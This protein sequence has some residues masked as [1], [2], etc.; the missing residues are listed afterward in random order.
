MA[1]NRNPLSYTG[2]V[3]ADTAR[4]GDAQFDSGDFSVDDNGKV[5]LAAAS[6]AETFSTDSGTVTPAS[7]A[8]TVSGGEGIDT[9]GSGSTLTIS[10]EDASTSNKGVASFAA[11]EFDVS[12]GAVSLADEGI[13]QDFWD[14][15]YVNAKFHDPVISVQADGTVASGVD[16][17][18]NVMHVGDGIMMEQYNIGT[19]T[20][21]VPT[22]SASGLLVSLDQT[23]DEGAEFGLGITTRSRCAF[24]AQTDACFVEVTATFADASGVDPFYV[25]FR[26]LEGYN[27][28]LGSYTDYF[29]LGVEGTANP[30]KIQFQTNLNGGVAATTDS[31]DTWAD[32]ATKTIRVNVSAGGVATGLIDGAS[33]TTEPSTF[34]FDADTIIPF[35]WFLH[36]TTSPGDIHITSF[37]CGLQ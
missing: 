30:N 37:K 17:E 35:I 3:K 18:V 34:T 1:N 33:P 31:T 32:A 15:D 29:V 24:T 23:D 16:T 11:A 8:I 25:G 36:G 9:S 10:G 4:L 20:I 26:K 2:R 27:S 7:S 14:Y 6:V 28:T 21:I 12:S 19:K 13:R 5:S 22:I